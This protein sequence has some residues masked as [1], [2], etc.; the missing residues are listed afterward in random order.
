MCGFGSASFVLR[1][2]GVSLSLL[3]ACPLNTLRKSLVAGGDRGAVNVKTTPR[4]QA[5]HQTRRT[6][7]QPITDKMAEVGGGGGWGGG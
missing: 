1:V 6:T 7:S 5:G 4:G 2:V 3:A